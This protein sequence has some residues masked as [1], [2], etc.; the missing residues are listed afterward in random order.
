MEEVLDKEL[1]EIFAQ[2]FAPMILDQP[3]DIVFDI[4]GVIL[5]DEQ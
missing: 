1:L 4:S 5:T 2:Y 3:E